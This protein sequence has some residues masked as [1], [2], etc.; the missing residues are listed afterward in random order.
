M[1]LSLLTSETSLLVIVLPLI[2]CPVAVRRTCL[3][4]RVLGVKRNISVCVCEDKRA[5]VSMHKVSYR[6]PCW[7]A[8]RSLTVKRMGWSMALEYSLVDLFRL[9]SIFSLQL[10][11]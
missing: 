3:P 8:A 5:L 6:E 4:F 10:S 1:H 9:Q 2:G 11:F 7:Y